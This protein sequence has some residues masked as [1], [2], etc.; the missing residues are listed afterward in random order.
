MYT[1]LSGDDERRKTMCSLIEGV[2][3]LSYDEGEDSLEAIEVSTLTSQ[4][5][6]RS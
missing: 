5:F 4:T 6:C 2:L 1:K 3:L